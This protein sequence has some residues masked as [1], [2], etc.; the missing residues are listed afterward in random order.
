V[1]DGFHDRE[2]NLAMCY[3][4]DNCAKIL[5][6]LDLILTIK[7]EVKKLK[8]NMTRNKTRKFWREIWSN[9]SK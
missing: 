4:S 7:K 6:G 3:M 1:K 9:R 2:I 8:Q 5:K